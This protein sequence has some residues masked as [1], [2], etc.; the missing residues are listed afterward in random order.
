[1]TPHI[2]QPSLRDATILR[3]RM[4]AINDL[5]KFKRQYAAEQLRKDEART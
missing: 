4:Q 5:P 2:I 3:R 1:M